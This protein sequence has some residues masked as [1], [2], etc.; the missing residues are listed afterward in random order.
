MIK[1]LLLKPYF[2]HF[3]GSRMKPAGLLESILLQKF[4]HGCDECVQS[5]STCMLCDLHV[6]HHVKHYIITF[7][8]FH[9]GI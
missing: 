4:L 8:L 2:K 7:Q 3:R 1:L 9:K 5:R 6:Q